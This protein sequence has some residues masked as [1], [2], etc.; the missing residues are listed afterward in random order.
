MAAI[1]LSAE[2]IAAWD[3]N[4][5]WWDENIGDSG[6]GNDFY[7]QLELPALERLAGVEAGERALDLATGNG[8]VA[9][10]LAGKGAVVTA[11]DSSP[12]MVEL[13]RQRAQEGSAVSFQLLDITDPGQL[14]KFIRNMQP[15]SIREDGKR[16]I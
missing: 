4:A 2:A 11:T 8:V 14:E 7:R 12:R 5:T 15:V 9:R 16:R 3:A 13:A 1:S 6:S 10:W